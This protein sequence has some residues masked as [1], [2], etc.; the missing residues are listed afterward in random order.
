MEPAIQPCLNYSVLEINVAHLVAPRYL[1]FN[2]FLQMRNLLLFQVDFFLLFLD[3]LQ[4]AVRGPTAVDLF[5]LVSYL[6]SCEN[7]CCFVFIIVFQLAQQFLP[8]FE[9]VF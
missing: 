1:E 7:D 6:F 8:L 9:S 4:R 5:F 3:V 2:L